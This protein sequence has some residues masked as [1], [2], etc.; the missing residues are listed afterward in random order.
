[1][2]LCSSLAARNSQHL[3]RSE[4]AI[5]NGPPPRALLTPKLTYNWR[6]SL[7][8]KTG[9]WS[10]WE[11]FFTPEIRHRPNEDYFRQI[12]LLSLSQT[13][14]R[15]TRLISDCLAT[16]VKSKLMASVGGESNQSIFNHLLW[17]FRFGIPNTGPNGPIK[18]QTFLSLK[19]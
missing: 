6:L 19:W 2:T 18:K 12:N 7:K 15:L 1:M 9:Q 13:E 4:W 16:T 10:A 17:A 5:G 11:T 3:L 14:R 8:S